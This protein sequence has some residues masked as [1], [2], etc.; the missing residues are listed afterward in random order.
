MY[1]FIFK[2]DL[3]TKVYES[4]GNYSSSKEAKYYGELFYDSD[5]FP[6]VETIEGVKVDII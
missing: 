5:K 6:S 3:G 1:K 2:D 4:V